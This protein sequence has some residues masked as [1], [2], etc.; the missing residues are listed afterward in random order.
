MFVQQPVR[1]DVPRYTLASGSRVLHSL[2]ITCLVCLSFLASSGTVGAAGPDAVQGTAIRP[3][4]ITIPAIGV[5]APVEQVGLDAR[6]AVGVPQQWGDAAWFQDGYLA[7]DTGNA[8]IVGHLDST[9]GPA[10][11]S[12]LGQLR[13]GAQIIVD[14][15]TTRLTF[16]VES[17]VR[18]VDAQ[19]P[20]EHV[21]GPAGVSR[22]NLVTCAG[23]FDAQT[24]KYTDRLVVYSVLQSVQPPAPTATSR[25]FT[26]TG[27]YIV[28]DDAQAK[29]LTEFNRLGGIQALGYPISRRFQLEGFVVQGFQKAILQWHPDTGQATFVNVLDWMH[30][31]GSDAWLASQQMTP[32]PADNSGDT[33]LSWPEVVTRHQSVL[34]GNAALRTAYTAVDDP[35]G[36]YGLPT[37]DIVDEGPALVIRCQRAVLQ[38]WKQDVPWATAGQVTVANG[39]DLAKQAGLIPAASTAT[40]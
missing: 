25:Y 18:Y 8:V 2:I 24:G 14:D 21:Y 10:V 38:L 30:D 1:H 40:Q 3:T 32:P 34:A 26:E 29:F 28:A 12:R 36:R 4:H 19:S 11:F 13:P 9:S 5:D 22:L 20:M 35:V 33:G 16:A 6:G 23:D 27:G 15:G 39:G 31:Q 17:L 37:S 7:G